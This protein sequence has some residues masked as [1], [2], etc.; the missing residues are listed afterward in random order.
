MIGGSPNCFNTLPIFLSDPQVS[1][2][3]SCSLVARHVI[4]IKIIFHL[5]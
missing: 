5:G 2:G 3:K 1:F 4:L